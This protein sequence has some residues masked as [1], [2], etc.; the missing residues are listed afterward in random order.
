MISPWAWGGLM[1][2]AAIVLI[3][4]V[5]TTSTGCSTGAHRDARS[6]QAG[7]NDTYAPNMVKQGVSPVSACKQTAAAV[8]GW[9]PNP[10]NPLDYEAGCEQH[11]H[12]VGYKW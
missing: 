5:L 3:L 11:L 1:G 8:N 7:Y 4:I 2:N 12:D 6:Y 9:N 10:Y